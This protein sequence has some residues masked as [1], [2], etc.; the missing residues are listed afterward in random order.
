MSNVL[1]YVN[2][3]LTI[4]VLATSAL[5]AL[6]MMR[7]RRQRDRFIRRLDAVVEIVSRENYLLT[8]ARYVREAQTEVLFLSSTI[9]R[10]EDQSAL[11]ELRS[12]RNKAIKRT[13]TYQAII[14]EES[15]RIEGGYELFEAKVDVLVSE[16]LL[17]SDV[18]LTIIDG[19]VAVI[20]L[21][22]RPGGPSENG[23]TIHS[24]PLIDLLSKYYQSL[25]PDANSFKLYAS[26]RILQ[27]QEARN[28]LPAIK[29]WTG[30]P[31]EV[32]REW[33][34]AMKQEDS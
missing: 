22:L 30:I 2:I 13:T 3:G 7:E 20:G 15:G 1:V 9:T 26:R 6:L 14:P 16:R 29:E 27:L 34:N 21:P 23:V 5:S 11:K 25:L 10:Q 24:G 12:A 31:P 32:Q 18:N 8:L 4:A 19:E 17:D 33:T 28:G